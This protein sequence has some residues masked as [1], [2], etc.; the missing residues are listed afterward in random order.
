MSHTESHPKSPAQNPRV[1]DGTNEMRAALK[2]LL[3]LRRK[4][5]SAADS[6]I[7]LS[8]IHPDY[9]SSAVNLLSYLALRRHDIRLPQKQLAGL[10]LSS[11]GRCEADV[12][13]SVD[14]IINL[15]QR[16]TSGEEHSVLPVM[17]PSTALDSSSLLD[18]GLALF[19]SHPKARAVRIM[20]TMPSGAADDYR[21]VE[22]LLAAGMDCQRINCAHDDP[23]TWLQMIE[24]LRTASKRLGKPCQ[25]VMDLAGPKLRTGPIALRPP[26]MKIRPARDSSGNVKK[27]GQAHLISDANHLG[28]D[29]IL[30]PQK[31]LRHIEVDDVLKFRDSRGSKRE[32]RVSEADDF[33]CWVELHRTAYV[34]PGTALKLKAPRGRKPSAKV[35]AVHPQPQTI[36]L[37]EDDL[38]VLCQEN[39]E[40]LAA[41]YDDDGNLISPARIS[42][43]SSAIFETAVVGDPIWFDDGK[44]G[45][46]I[47]ARQTDALEIKVHHA[48]D[49][50]KLKADKGINLPA[51]D[52][53]LG[54]LSD[55][56]ITALEFASQHADIVELSFA[57]EAKDVTALLGHLERLNS[58]SL[59][60]VL[61]IETR[62]GFENLP[63]LLLA[64]MR[65]PRLGV[66]IARGDLAVETGFE[67][68]AELQEEMLCLCEAA[69]V[70][71]IWATQVLETLAKTGAP[72][73][74]EITDA[75]MGVRAEC[76]MLN[77]GRHI[78]KAI[79]T[80]DDLL[81]RMQNHHDKKRDMMRKLNVARLPTQLG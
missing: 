22:S 38:L 25:V 45:G 1:A 65:S 18:H 74:A 17:A 40:G 71:V 20:V 26:V 76:V 79:A 34:V 30:L 68:T 53:K 7:D 24:H 50:V 57:N 81:K 33:G 60:I 37:H 19:G 11:L 63:E 64:G 29:C 39:L 14:R 28:N 73:R 59:G 55:D 32:M 52:L 66:M 51:T 54:A 23:D 3:F 10:G 16:V 44:I 21:M 36:R 49:G 47:V 41:S 2:S 61:K 78:L 5:Q 70:P 58:N 35:L 77:K 62:R 4:M 75:A 56:D 8:H 31:W 12:L 43:N 69:H 13:G 80:L 15:L 48:P 27:P 9:H 6:A 72:T 46:V 67:R 42:C